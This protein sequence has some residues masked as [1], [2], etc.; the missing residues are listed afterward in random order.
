[1]RCTYCGEGHKQ[2]DCEA[3]SPKCINCGGP[4]RTLA[5][6]CKVRKDLIK[7]KSKEIRERS[8]SRT[9]Q[10]AQQDFAGARSFAAAAG[11]GSEG[12]TR[13]QETIAPLTKEETKDMLTVIMS[14]IVYGHYMEALVPS[15]F[16]ENVSEVYRLNGLGTVK[17]PTPPMAASVMEVC[18]EVFRERSKA[19]TQQ[20]AEEEREDTSTSRDLDLE[21]DLE[22]EVIEE[23]SMEIETFVKRHRESI[24]PPQREE[25]RKKEERN[26]RGISKETPRTFETTHTAD[27]KVHVRSSTKNSRGKAR[28]SKRD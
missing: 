20:E 15:S 3:A 28:E 19:E 24:T 25:K 2:A 4:H 23:E 1:M 18:R 26:S 6:V 13:G 27:I 14:A 7:K 8:K 21:V 16:Q 17:L 10:G 22:D 5:A 11:A 12:S 9:R